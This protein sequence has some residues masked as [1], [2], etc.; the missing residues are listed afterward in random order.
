[1]CKIILCVTTF[2][3]IYKN[4][5]ILLTSLLMSRTDIQ[6]IFDCRHPATIHASF[7]LL[8]L[9]FKTT[10]VRVRKEGT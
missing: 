4:N 1:M 3:P 7:P 9:F 5:I 2:S 10:H 8:V 6:Q